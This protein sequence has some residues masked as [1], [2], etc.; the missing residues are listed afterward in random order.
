[1]VTT[2]IRVGEDHSYIWTEQHRDTQHIIIS[3]LKNKE[4]QSLQ[5][6]D[7]EEHTHLRTEQQRDTFN[8]T[9]RDR[10]TSSQR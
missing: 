3:A 6:R 1:M 8:S 7:R 5:V 2:K 4:T 10:K 9:L